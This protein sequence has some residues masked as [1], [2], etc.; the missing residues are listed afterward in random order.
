MLTRTQ[1][2]TLRYGSITRITIAYFSTN[3]PKLPA[4]FRFQSLLTQ[5][6]TEFVDNPSCIYP[7]IPPTKNL[8]T[9]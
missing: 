8:A 6:S 5:L 1:P 4:T 2:N 9:K 3:P 7:Q